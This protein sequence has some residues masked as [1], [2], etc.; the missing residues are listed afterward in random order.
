MN[1]SEPPLVDGAFLR[2]LQN[3]RKG[4][5]LTELSDALRRVVE[6]VSTAKKP[7]T[8]VLT[9][10]ISPTG[11]VY[12]LTPVVTVKLPREIKPAALFYL[13]EQFNLVREDPNQQTLALTPLTGGTAET[14]AAPTA[15]TPQSHAR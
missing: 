5:V 13:D 3:Y 15:A 11:E 9:V 2:T 4:A 8:L 14:S 10:E 12:A 1:A 6:A 7:G